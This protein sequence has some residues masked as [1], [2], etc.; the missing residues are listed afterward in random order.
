MAGEVYRISP[1][2]LDTPENSVCPPDGQLEAARNNISNTM[3]E[4]LIEYV[5]NITTTTYTI[6]ACGGSGWRRVALLDMSDP[7]Q[8]CPEQWRLY[9][10]DTVRACGR[11]TSGGGS[12][13]S[14]T[15]NSSGNAYTQVCGRVTGYQ[16]ASPD[17]SEDFGDFMF[18]INDYYLDGVSITYG[19]PRQ[20]I[21]SLFT[22][23]RNSQCCSEQHFSNVEPYSFIGNNTFCDTGSNTSGWVYELYTS[24]PLWDGSTQC[25]N[26]PNCCASYPGPL[27]HTILASPSTSDIEVRICGDQATTDED[28]PVGLVEIHQ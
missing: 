13:D 27:F 18:D 9:E 3:S 1:A 8:T 10:Q 2:I 16:Y 4:I 22:A 17:A 7:A 24:Y 26:N 19:S 15:F 20:H 28:N 5:A 11:Q 6:P 25:A 21:W 14:V 23:L 12:C